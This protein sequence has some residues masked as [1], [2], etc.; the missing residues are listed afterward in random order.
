[1]MPRDLK[2]REFKQKATDSQVW[3]CLGVE[4]RAQR[5]QDL[6]ARIGPCPCRSLSHCPAVHATC[7][8]GGGSPQM[9]PWFGP[10]SPSQ[11]LSIAP[12][13]SFS[14]TSCEDRHR[15]RRSRPALFLLHLFLFGCGL[16]GVPCPFLQA[17]PLPSEL[18]APSMGVRLTIYHAPHHLLLQRLHHLPLSRHCA[19][20]FS[21]QEMVCLAVPG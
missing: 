5:S 6:G 15:V 12:S 13:F 11:M 19:L 7:G 14:S 18:L 16:P 20:P 2:I 1:M 4:H 9:E 21:S 8:S 17:R 3:V 10:S